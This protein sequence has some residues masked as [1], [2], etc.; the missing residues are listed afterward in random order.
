MNTYS[1]VS[2]LPIEIDSYDLEGLSV[3]VSPEFTRRTTVIRLH[4]RGELG[5]GED[6]TYSPEDQ[7]AFQGEGPTPP[8]PPRGPGGLPGRSPDPPSFRL[9]PHNRLLQRARRAAVALARRAGARPGP[10]LS[11]LGVRERSARPCAP[12]GREVARR[13]ARA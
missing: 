2:D 12:P 3:E 13:G 9:A 1:L 6:P 10:A 4:G 8:R 11:P 7:E 5:I